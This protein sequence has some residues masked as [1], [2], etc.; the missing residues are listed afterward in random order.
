MSR[1]CVIR[2]SSGHQPHRVGRKNPPLWRVFSFITRV[3]GPGVAPGLRDYAPS[4]LTAGVGL[5]LHPPKCVS[6]W[7]SLAYSLYGVPSQLRRCGG[8]PRCCPASSF[9][10]WEFTDTA[11]ESIEIA[12]DCAHFFINEPRVQRYTTPHI[13]N[14]L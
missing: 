9:G 13:A 2:T 12:P 8:F 5:Y 11:K 3:A 10:L 7:W 14:A 1:Y 6:F 4:R